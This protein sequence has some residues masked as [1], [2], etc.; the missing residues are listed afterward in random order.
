MKVIF[1]ALAASALRV[2]SDPEEDKVLAAVEQAIAA[3]TQS[4]AADQVAD[5]GSSADPGPDAPQVESAAVVS[6]EEETAKP[7][8]E[9]DSIMAKYD[10]EEKQ[11]DYLKSDAYKAKIK[12]KEDAKIKEEEDQVQ[13][14]EETLGQIESN[15]DLLGKKKANEHAA[16]DDDFL[17]TLFKNY[18][19]NGKDGIQ[20]I[21]KD[22]AYLAAAKC[23]ERFR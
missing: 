20:I 9:V 11:K 23:V 18:A 19:T 13:Q 12:A 6:S 22:K 4:E 15:R 16:E 21:T 17:Q 5:S 3:E 10:N 2:H 1:L 7:Q 8:D 14:L